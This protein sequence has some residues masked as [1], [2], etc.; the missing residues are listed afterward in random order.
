M[1]Q[2]ARNPS[3][4]L[5]SRLSAIKPLH[6]LACVVKETDRLRRAK[7]ISTKEQAGILVCT[8]LTLGH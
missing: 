2:V 3:L 1:A 5:P 8:L 7:I 6:E 4:A